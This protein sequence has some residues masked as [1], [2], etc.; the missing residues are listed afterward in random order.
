MKSILGVSR[1]PFLLLPITLIVSGV[2]AS[3]YDAQTAIAPLPAILA[4]IGLVALHIGVNSLNE[5]GDMRS[6]IDLHTTRTPFSGGSGTLPAG[7]LSIR[8]AMIWGLFT[9][10][11]GLAIGVW[12]LFQVGWPLLPIVLLGG[13]AVLAYTPLLLKIGV[14][15]IFAGL[16]LGGL[17]VLGASL[18]Q[19]SQIGAATIAA[20]IPAFFMTFNLLLLNEFPDEGP[21]R[22]GGRRHLVILMGRRGAALV[23]ALAVF[24]VVASI[25]VAVA[26]QVLPVV[27]LVAL[28]P[29]FAA[30]P[31]VRWA[32]SR[33]R[34]PVPMPALGGNVIW[35]LATNLL[36]GGALGLA[37]WQGW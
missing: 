10:A 11:I 5:A 14:G 27:A 6:G 7:G 34:E 31:A 26:L 1:G 12:F 16:G 19:D 2:A 24:G 3:A 35:N 23:Y 20:C 18:V 9:T 21:D 17:P 28:L 33:P 15:E 37:V 22:A 36:M 29:T 32:L 8:A 30:V 4:L 13:F 25:V